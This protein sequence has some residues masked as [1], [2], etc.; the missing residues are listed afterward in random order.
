MTQLERVMVFIDNRNIY[1]GFKK[2]QFDCDY[3]LLLNQLIKGREN[4]GAHLFMGIK[5]P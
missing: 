4:R 5:M 1:Y 3:R 2:R